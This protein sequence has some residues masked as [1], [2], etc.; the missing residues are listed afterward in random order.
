MPGSMAGE[1][2]VRI[3]VQI[4]ILKCH[5]GDHTKWSNWKQVT[6]IPDSLTSFGLYDILGFLRTMVSIL[7]DSYIPEKNCHLEG[8]TLIWQNL[9]ILCHF[10]LAIT[11]T[12]ATMRWECFLRGSAHRSW[13]CHMT[14]AWQSWVVADV[15]CERAE[16]LSCFQVY[17]AELKFNRAYATWVWQCASLWPTTDF[18]GAYRVPMARHINKDMRTCRDQFPLF[19]YQ[20]STTLV[21]ANSEK[22]KLFFGA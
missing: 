20:V 14:G 21:L 9:A 19:V 16:I 5:G 13:T 17:S 10:R 2:D 4:C 12:L 3:F 22:G 18:S 1:K 11:T 8:F 7:G 6:D 15:R